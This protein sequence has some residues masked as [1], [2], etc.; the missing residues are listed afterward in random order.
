MHAVA[1]EW[2]SAMEAVAV[3]FVRGLTLRQVGDLLHFDWATERSTTFA[4][5][6]EQQD[7]YSGEH[8]V[9]VE[10]AESDRGSWLVLIEPNGYLASLP[11]ALE[12]LSDADVA[13]SVYWNVNAQMRFAIYAD[14]ILVRSFDPLLTDLG[15][16]GEPLPEEQGLRFGVE[17]E[18]RADAMTL[19][20]RLTGVALDRRSVLDAPHP[21]WTATGF[22]AG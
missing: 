9:Q 5:A 16:E 13:V 1:Y 4:E 21:T 7:F 18:P 6:E 19:A 12:A 15:P 20:Q 17:G 14:G 8:A 22:T 3:T 11:E 2:V 10:A